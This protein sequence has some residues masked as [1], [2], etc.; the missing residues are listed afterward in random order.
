MKNVEVKVT[1]SSEPNP[2]KYAI[3]V[4][5]TAQ[6]GKAASEALE[7]QNKATILSISCQTKSLRRWE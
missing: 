5:Q 4:K 3:L 2:E 6:I 7:R 1:S